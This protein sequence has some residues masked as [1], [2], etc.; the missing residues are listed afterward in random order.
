MS[1]SERPR[2]ADFAPSTPEPQPHTGRWFQT[3]SGTFGQFMP[4]T[5]ADKIQRRRE[6]ICMEEI[7]LDFTG[8]TEACQRP[9]VSVAFDTFNRG[10]YP[11]CRDHA[12]GHV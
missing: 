4:S 2:L 12:A 11:V 7:T 10:H 8:R 9:A 3:E 1:D 5:F 6:G